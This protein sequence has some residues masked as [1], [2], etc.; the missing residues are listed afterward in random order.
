MQHVRW[1]DAFARGRRR[2]FHDARGPHVAERRKRKIGAGI[3]RLIHDHDRSPQPEHIH[4][5]R[6]RL[7]IRPRQQIG[8]SVRG[9]IQQM[10]GKTSVLFIHLSPGRITTYT[11]ISTARSLRRMFAAISAPCSVKAQ[12]R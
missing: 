5:R 11:L 10:L 4:Q 6:L 2:K 7:S 12:G 1:R 9:Q 8:E 3:V